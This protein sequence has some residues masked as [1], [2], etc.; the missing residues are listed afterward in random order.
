MGGIHEGLVVDYWLGYL[1]GLDPGTNVGNEHLLSN[2]K[3][4]VRTLGDLVEI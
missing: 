1:D 4:L 2:G 3:I